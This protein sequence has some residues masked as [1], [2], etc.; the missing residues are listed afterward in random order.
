MWY[1]RGGREEIDFPP[2]HNGRKK[3]SNQC[4]MI[5]LMPLLLAEELPEL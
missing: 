4:Q 2:L 1:K 3:G 5:D